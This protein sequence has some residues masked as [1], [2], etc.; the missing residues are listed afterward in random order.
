MDYAV[1]AVPQLS[2]THP[3][4]GVPFAVDLQKYSV[5]RPVLIAMSPI[6]SGVVPS[7]LG[8]SVTTKI[9]GLSFDHF[10]IAILT[11]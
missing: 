2:I 4:A 9:C 3:E 8:L 10:L 6:L 7:L 11:S 5:I 1:P